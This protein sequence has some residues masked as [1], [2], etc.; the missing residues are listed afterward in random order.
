[1]SHK[2]LECILNPAD[3]WH[4]QGNFRIYRF[5]ESIPGTSDVLGLWWNLDVYLKLKHPEREQETFTFYIIQ[6]YTFFPFK[7]V[8]RIIITFLNFKNT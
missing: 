8:L 3:L 6:F 5:L 7:Y 4:H 1:M 2:G